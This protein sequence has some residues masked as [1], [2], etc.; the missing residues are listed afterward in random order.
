MIDY[1]IDCM[2][3]RFGDFLKHN[4]SGFVYIPKNA[5]SFIKKLLPDWE[6]TNYFV[7]PAVKYFVIL[8]DPIERWI[9]AT[10]EWYF[11]LDT[12]IAV[13]Q[14][15]NIASNNI[16]LD[17]HTIPQICFIKHL[18]LDS[19]NFYNLSTHALDKIALDLNVQNP[20]LTKTYSSN[21]DIEKNNF[22][23]TLVSYMK[24][25]SMIYD[26]LYKSYEADYQLLNTKKVKFD[27]RRNQ[28][29]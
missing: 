8:R 28:K 14:I 20:N 19:I 13:D 27:F 22:K 15:I 23:K 11:R 26:L 25:N 18:S 1:S 12:N 10:T 5:S 17:E 29:T 16:F 2:R 7:S 24:Q 4:D 9:S 21:T 6:Q 3:H